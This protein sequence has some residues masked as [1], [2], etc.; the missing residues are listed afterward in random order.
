[1]DV[2]SMLAQI[3]ENHQASLHALSTQVHA[4]RDTCD[5]QEKEIQLLRQTFARDNAKAVVERM[6]LRRQ[7]EEARAS[8]SALSETVTLLNHELQTKSMES[9]DVDQQCICTKSLILVAW[10]S[11]TA[12]I[13]NSIAILELALR[14]RFRRPCFPRNRDL[15]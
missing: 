3:Q 8:A 4:L 7:L 13:D 1:M 2:Q 10:T 5:L 12:S 11:T 9:D 14:L 15:S 6:L